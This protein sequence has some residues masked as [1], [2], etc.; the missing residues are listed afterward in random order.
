M[1]APRG[2]CPR[3]VTLAGCK[4]YQGCRSRRCQIVVWFCASLVKQLS[5]RFAPAHSVFNTV[6]QLKYGYLSKSICYW[7]PLP[8]NDATIELQHVLLST[9]R[10]VH[11]PRHCRLPRPLSAIPR[12]E[13]RLDGEGCSRPAALGYIVWRAIRRREWFRRSPSLH[14][15]H[16][17]LAG[18]C[19]LVFVAGLSASSTSSRVGLLL[20]CI[21][22]GKRFL[23]ATYPVDWDEA[24]DRQCF[25][26]TC[27]K[28]LS[29]GWQFGED[30]I[31]HVVKQGRYRHNSKGIAQVDI[32]IDITVDIVQIHNNRRRHQ[33][34]NEAKK[35]STQ[36]NR[37]ALP[38]QHE[39]QIPRL[40]QCD[41]Q[42]GCPAITE[43]KQG[44]TKVDS[45]RRHPATAAAAKQIGDPDRRAGI[46]PRVAGGEPPAAEWAECVEGESSAGEHEPALA[47]LLRL[48]STKGYDTVR[49]S[50]FFSFVYI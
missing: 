15:Q 42:D 8:A 26:S 50:P 19:A 38:H 12:S 2:R 49:K 21:G 23:V 9:T 14:D 43:H 31:E 16:V 3:Q 11:P 10:H 32:D 24:P 30:R 44:V 25:W 17:C 1:I 7:L 37:E 6:Y 41:P 20:T 27:K 35:S 45:Q 18:G 22:C 36:R 4:I 46:Y 40:G 28:K 13:H 47:K 39:R 48:I 29:W 5:I 33:R 34:S